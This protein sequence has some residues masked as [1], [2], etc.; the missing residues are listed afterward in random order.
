[1]SAGGGT[2][3][4]ARGAPGRRDGWGA[5]LLEFGRMAGPFWG[6]GR[7]PVVLA[8]VLAALTAL[9]V[10]VPV[11][12]NLWTENL[13]DSLAN[14]DLDRFL[15]LL[16]A[17]A[18]IIGANVLI[19]TVH[20]VVKRRLQIRWRD[21]LTGIVIGDWMADGRHYQVSFMPGE[22]GNP[23][24]RIAE[25]ARIATEYAI[26]LAHSLFYVLLLGLSFL[27]ILWTL[28]GE[29]EISLLGRDMR[30]PGHL[31]WAAT[32]YAAIGMTVALLVGRPLVPATDWRQTV[33]ADFR[34]GLAHA[35]ENSPAIAMARG[36]MEERRRLDL[37]FAGV[38]LAW[39]AQTAAFVRIFFY[40]S[41]WSVLT[42]VFPVLVAAPRYILGAITL[43]VLMQTAQ[44]MVQFISALSWPVDNLAKLIEWRASAQRV[45][46][47][48]GALHG[49]ASEVALVD[50][51]GVAV[52]GG[53]AGVLSFDEVSLTDRSGE[54]IV[55]PFSLSIEQG[56][57]LVLDGETGAAARLFE[58]A[59]GLWPWGGGRIMLP[60]GERLYFMPQ[61]PYLPIAPLREALAYP[62]SAADLPDDAV[63]QA[64]MRAGLPH[65]AVRLDERGNW[66]RRLSADERQRLG[67]ARLLLHRPRWVFLDDPSNALDDAG[68]AAMA[69]L[70]QQEFAKATLVVIGDA[71]ELAAGP[72]RRVR[73][74]REAG[75][76]VVREAGA[77]AGSAGPPLFRRDVGE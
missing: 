35:R 25:D 5:F 17:L 8:V 3:K 20:L 39:R 13:F 70:L 77:G 66:E 24:G 12:L 57:R 15:L 56:E 72:V 36:E 28:S 33:E 55:R 29:L 2:K 42:Q 14:R 74:E 11:A 65:L 38:A 60:E 31:V 9:Q 41:S 67:F 44:A 49:L 58:A 10:A 6:S 73:L 23:D 53:G 40:S 69:Q 21:W 51:R 48:R 71:L 47:L 63:A 26:D 62:E 68:R 61:R 16:G 22:H 52:L 27:G 4:V 76:V 50:S 34:F 18:G 43:G 7:I 19:V 46:G 32:L 64:L 59:A 1:M 30:L 45:A 75:A 54:L 37:L